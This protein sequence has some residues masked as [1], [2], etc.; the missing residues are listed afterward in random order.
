[1]ILSYLPF[2][3][4]GKEEEKGRAYR[5]EL[6]SSPFWTRTLLVNFHDNLSFDEVLFWLV[7]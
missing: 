4:G 7:E 6:V 3:F 2:I 5:Q 1:M